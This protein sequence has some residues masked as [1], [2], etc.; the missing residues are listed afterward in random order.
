MVKSDK[1]ILYTEVF[2]SKVGLPQ[3]YDENDNPIA[4][5]TENPLPVQL[6]GAG[7]EGKSAYDVAVDNGF[8]GSE[9]EWLESLKGEPGDKGN[10]FTYDDFTSEQLESLRGRQGD[11]GRDADPQFTQEQVDALL[12]LINEPGEE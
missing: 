10:P 8:E 1:K 11:P 3:F 6:S 2:G 9:S 12:G 4:I 5:S 7:V